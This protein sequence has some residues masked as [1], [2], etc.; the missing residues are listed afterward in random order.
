VNVHLSVSLLSSLSLSLWIKDEKEDQEN[1]GILCKKKSAQE[2]LLEEQLQV[3]AY[4]NNTNV[5]F[6]ENEQSR[7]TW[8]RDVVTRKNKQGQ[9]QGQEEDEQGLVLV[10]ASIVVQRLR[11][12]VFTK[13]GYI[14]SAGIAIASNKM[15]S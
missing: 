4:S 3:L 9:D 5:I 7:D 11:D 10:A 6:L 2:M 14:L 15:L 8:F 12:S 13:T 1:E